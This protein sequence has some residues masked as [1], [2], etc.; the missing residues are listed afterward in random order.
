MAM[1]SVAPAGSRAEQRG[2]VI[3]PEEGVTRIRRRPLVIE[4]IHVV[5]H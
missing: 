2:E 3:N 5:P 1:C 4:C